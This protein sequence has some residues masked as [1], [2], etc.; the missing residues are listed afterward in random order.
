MEPPHRGRMFNMHREPFSPC[1][2]RNKMD[3]LVVPLDVQVF[4]L[5]AFLNTAGF[6]GVLPPPLLGASFNHP[7]AEFKPSDEVPASHSVKSAQPG[8]THRPLPECRQT[9]ALVRFR[10][11]GDFCAEQLSLPL[12]QR[13]LCGCR[14]GEV[15]ECGMQGFL[16]LWHAGNGL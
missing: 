8:I 2:L 11:F 9:A 13:V 14:Y 10:Q 3:N 4:G 12:L 16:V 1:M 5:R 6:W 15:L 7:K